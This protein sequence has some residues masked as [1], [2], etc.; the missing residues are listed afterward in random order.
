[1][2]EVLPNEI[3]G[4]IFT[5]HAKLEWRAPA[6]DGRVCRI[7]RQIVLNTP[8][9][10]S[11]LEISHDELP[12]IRDLRSWLDRS[13]IAPLYIRVIAPLYIRVNRMLTSDEYLYEPK[14]YNLLVDYHKRIAS[15]RLPWVDSS[16]FEGRGFPSLQLLDVKW[17]DP[18]QSS[19]PPMRWDSIPKLRSLRL[20]ATA[21]FPVPWGE[22]P[23][24][25]VL[26]LCYTG[27]LSLPQY[28]QSLTTLMLANVSIWAKISGQ[29]SLPSLTYLSLYDV[30]GLKPYIDAPHLIT[31]HEGWGTVRESFPA[32]VLSLV[33]YGV[34]GLND[35]LLTEWH[36]CFPNILRLSIRARLEVLTSFLDTLFRHPHTLPALQTIS[37]RVT[38]ESFTH[39]YRV[40]MEDHVRVRSEACQRD[41]A[42]Y[43]E[44]ELPFR[45]P[46]FFGEVRYYPIMVITL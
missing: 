20:R 45:I 36:H 22:L 43:F 1:M 4:A 46:L 16:F 41:V 5:E 32:P 8:R 17:W 33:E 40:I 30:T 6:I 7:W 38:G 9:A 10:W 27:L 31:Y 19:S 13:G 44:T 28:S 18:S 23:L 35:S 15:L 12:R 34:Y 24:L 25:E 11:Y 3:M 29:V 21:W 2:H 14:L 42:L 26:V 39:G 37:A